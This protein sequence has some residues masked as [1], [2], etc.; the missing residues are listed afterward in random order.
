MKKTKGP[1]LPRSITSK[2]H[3]V[4]FFGHLYLVD[5]SSFH[6]DDRFFDEA[7]GEVQYV[8]RDGKPAFTPAQARRRDELMALAWE[9][10]SDA[11]LDIYELGIW[12]GALL[13][14]SEPADAHDA[15]EWLRARI[16]S[17]A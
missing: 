5:N 3:I 2:E 1:P 10:S 15:P 14:F 11:G 8:G 9:V 13:G 17:W 16:R 12:V 7:S 6:P 4:D